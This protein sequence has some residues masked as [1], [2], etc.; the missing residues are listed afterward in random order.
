ME[1]KERDRVK[2]GRETDEKRGQESR[3][4]RYM[5]VLRKDREKYINHI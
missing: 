2:G 3:R 4:H 1:I 5:V